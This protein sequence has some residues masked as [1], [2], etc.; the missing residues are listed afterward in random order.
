MVPRAI[1]SYHAAWLLT[2]WLG[3][4][5][6][7]SQQHHSPR[8]DT[9]DP[10][11]LLLR[12]ADPAGRPIPGVRVFVDRDPYETIQA[13][14]PVEVQLSDPTPAVTDATGE[15]RI[16]CG[17]T[18]H[19]A[20]LLV[21]EGR[22]LRCAHL[23]G[24]GSA[25]D[26]LMSE[27]PAPLDV[28]LPKGG[29]A[30]VR[31]HGAPRG[32]RV[33]ALVGGDALLDSARARDDPW[34]PPYDYALT[35]G[36]DLEAGVVLD[37]LPAYVAVRLE[38]VTDEGL[39]SC[40]PTCVHL[41]SGEIRRIEWPLEEAVDVACLL[42]D[43]RGIGIEGAEVHLALPGYGLTDSLALES[44][45]AGRTDSEGRVTLVGVPP[46]RWRFVLEGPSPLLRRVTGLDWPVESRSV[47]VGRSEGDVVELIAHDVRRIKG[48]VVDPDGT[49]LAGEVTVRRIE[50][51]VPSNSATVTTCDAAGRFESGPLA[52]GTYQ[53]H[54]STRRSGDPRFAPSESHFAEPGETPL[55]LALRAGRAVEVAAVAPGTQEPLSARFALAS[56]AQSE[57][58]RYAHA[59]PLRALVRGLPAG[60][61]L[62]LARTAD[63]RVGV[64]RFVCEAQPTQPLAV[65][66][67]VDAGSAL[68]LRVPEGTLPMRSEVLV[69]GVYVE[70]VTL[71][72]GESVRVKLPSGFAGVRWRQAML[73]GRADVPADWRTWSRDLE[74]GAEHTLDLDLGP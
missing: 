9:G 34:F 62:V 42:R 55:R 30:E 14:D 44:L 70:D 53:V 65:H 58:P 24:T 54:A 11:S 50:D 74:S 21:A 46:G 26:T 25:G 51:G 66:V 27:S 64:T 17:D 68:V 61:W 10:P 1:V 36:G 56:L 57:E 29:R 3:S 37:G 73:D 49:P 41:S 13:R 40:L 7:A 48:I 52:P 23:W 22:S 38:L 20:A 8:S 19:A 6:L 63:G 47:V 39:V 71:L 16:R 5:G 69:Q 59:S 43:E 35:V 32:A 33:R 45:R 2:A 31:V 15:V 72:P 67:P 60:Q 28:V 12:V 4:T 18:V